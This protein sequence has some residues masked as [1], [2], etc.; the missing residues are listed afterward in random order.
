MVPFLAAPDTFAWSGRFAQFGIAGRP[1]LSRVWRDVRIAATGSQR[2]SL[3]TF[4]QMPAEGKKAL[5]LIIKADGQGSLEALRARM[6]SLLVTLK[7]LDRAVKSKPFE[8]SLL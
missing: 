3:E 6:E 5:N 2:V 7:E 4:M 1:E 8:E